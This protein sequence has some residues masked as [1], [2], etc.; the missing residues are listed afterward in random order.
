MT[1]IWYLPRPKIPTTALVLSFGALAVPVAAQLFFAD[2]AGEY[3]VLL[4]LLALVPAFL[5][6]YYRGWQGAATALAAGMA[7]LSVTQ[8]VV[9]ATGSGA[10]QSPLLL[11]VVVAYAGISLG[12][13]WVTEL[14]HRQRARAELMALTDEL[15]ELPN[16]RYAHLFLEKEFAAAQRGRPLTVIFFDIDRFKEY[17]DLYGHAAGDA[18]LVAFGKLLASKTRKMDFSARY[19]GEEFITVLSSCGLEGGLGFVERVRTALRSLELPCGPITVSV[20]VATYSP[21][22]ASRAELLAAADAALYRAKQ[23][24]R[25]CVRTATPIPVDQLKPA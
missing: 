9:K 11:A 21:E 14:L 13:G 7:V 5:L 24:G 6:A 8:V 10:G 23:E 2:G 1:P 18:A 16:R 4:W 15:T 20:G 3:E 17:N 22:M 25:D 19:G 12:I